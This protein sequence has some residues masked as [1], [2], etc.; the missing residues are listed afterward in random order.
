M[1]DVNIVA[2]QEAGKVV[3]SVVTAGSA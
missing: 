3:W 1:T 2:G